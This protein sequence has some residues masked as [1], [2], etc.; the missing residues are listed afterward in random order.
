MWLKRPIKFF[1][2]YIL[3]ATMFSCISLWLVITVAWCLLYPYVYD[4]M[5]YE[6]K[7][8]VFQFTDPLFEE[9]HS[10]KE[11]KKSAALTSY[12]I[13][14]KITVLLNKEKVE[15][16][17]INS[18]LIQVF[19]KKMVKLY[20]NISVDDGDLLIEM[21]DDDFELI[22][23]NGEYFVSRLILIDGGLLKMGIRTNGAFKFIEAIQERMF[24]I[25]VVT[26]IV[27][28][29][30]GVALQYRKRK[31]I[32]EIIDYCMQS[33]EC[34][35]LQ[36]SI[37]G[38]NH[39]GEYKSVFECINQIVVKSNLTINNLQDFSAKIAHD[40]RS[41]LTR[42]R[43]QLEFMLNQEAVHHKDI[44]KL[45]SEIEQL[46]KN[47]SSLMTISQL[48]TKSFEQ[49]EIKFDFR[50]LMT[51]LREMY[52]PVC[53][54]HHINCTWQ[55][56]SKPCWQIGN[57]NL[58]FQALS[59]LIDNALKFTPINGNIVISL[60]NTSV[61]IIQVTD[62]GMGIPEHERENV[63]KRFYR[64]EKHYR[65]QGSGL[66]LSMVKAI[67]KHHNAKILLEGEQGLTVK[68]ILNQLVK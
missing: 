31:K 28:I 24:V 21:I 41:P 25:I 39:A 33:Q 43:G 34:N 63:F 14:E 64:M 55:V 42:L 37:V 68:I 16:Y 11:K 51:D 6:L 8:R 57:P 17:T 29:L 44:E 40:M 18:M 47:F 49:R 19:N 53:E 52:Q 38:I 9:I 46:E 20:S 45:L 27:S 54:D 66:G 10:D 65:I 58:W 50:K 60:D 12:E 59:N 3:T 15:A 26:F 35:G 5:I 7:G 62:S 1:R 36:P 4:T 67:C 22:T 32:S 30:I 23:A 2:N 56:S 48:E 13:A 61:P